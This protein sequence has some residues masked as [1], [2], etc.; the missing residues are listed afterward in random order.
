MLTIS[1]YNLEGSAEKSLIFWY[2]YGYSKK[3]DSY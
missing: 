2:V 3:F 1:V